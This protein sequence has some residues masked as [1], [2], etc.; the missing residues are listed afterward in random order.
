MHLKMLMTENKALTSEGFLL[1][2][3]SQEGEF[4][5]M[6]SYFIWAFIAT[7]AVTCKNEEKEIDE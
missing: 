2:E 4:R 1:L 3:R 7:W 5:K 6:G